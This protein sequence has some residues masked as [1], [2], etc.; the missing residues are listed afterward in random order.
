MTELTAKPGC[1]RCSIE[2]FRISK[3]HGIVVGGTDD[4]L[5]KNDLLHTIV[6]VLDI[7]G[8]FAFAL[9][10]AMAGIS[11]RLN[12]FGVLVLS[13]AASTSG[14]VIRDLLIGAVP[15]SALQDW[16][17]LAVWLAA[18]LLCVFWSMLIE[19]LSNPARM[20]DAVG[21]A[22][23]AVAG[24]QRRSRSDEIRSWLRCS[25]DGHR[26]RGNARRVACRNTGG[27]AFRP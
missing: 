15:V 8:T 6:L 14:G 19:R 18:G 23:F 24:T 2:A 3:R 1:T 16:R 13:F 17:Y 4:A 26:W 12:I 10:G 22:M 11:R 21:L 27:S 5:A 7:G 9:S 20:V 25:A